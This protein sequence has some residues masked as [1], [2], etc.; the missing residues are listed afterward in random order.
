MHTNQVNSVQGHTKN[1]PAF[2]QNNIK[3]SHHDAQ[4]LCTSTTG[5]TEVDASY[6]YILMLLVIEW[7]LDPS[8][9]NLSFPDDIHVRDEDLLELLSV[10]LY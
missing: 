2:G 3:N 1:T 8:V 6:N 7:G 5:R 9:M 4:T 10:L